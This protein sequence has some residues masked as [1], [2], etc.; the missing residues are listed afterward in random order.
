[1]GGILG[2]VADWLL[3]GRYWE[4]YT[5]FGRS[6]VSVEAFMCGF[7][8]LSL[9]AVCY[10]FISGRRDKIVKLYK[11]K[12]F[13]VKTFL[14]YIAMLVVGSVVILMLVELAE[15]SIMSAVIILIGLF[16]VYALVRLRSPKLMREYLWHAFLVVIV[17]MAIAAIS[18]GVWHIVFPNYWPDV[19]IEVGWSTMVLGFIPLSELIY[20]TLILGAVEIGFG[21]PPGRRIGKKSKKGV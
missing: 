17:M 14:I 16:I 20:W 19:L 1:M 2:M 15:L 9:V 21:E 7:C 12:T 5:F 18:Y 8:A 6:I 4:P 10:L 13:V 11:D 3:I